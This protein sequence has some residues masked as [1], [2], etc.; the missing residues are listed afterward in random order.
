MDR[1]LAGKNSS[2]AALHFGK[3]RHVV[4]AQGGAINDDRACASGTRIPQIIAMAL[5][6]CNS[7]PRTS[8]LCF[9]VC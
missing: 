1:E 4:T 6:Q 2:Q 5:A 7:V 8:T 9:M 3:T